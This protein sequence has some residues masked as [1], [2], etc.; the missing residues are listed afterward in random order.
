MSAFFSSYGGG[1]HHSAY[2]G[3]CPESRDWRPGDPMYAPEIDPTA[4]V[5]AF[6]TIDAGLRGPTRIG[7]RSWIMRHTH[8]GHDVQIGA[9]CELAPHC[10]VGGHVTLG[11]GVRV[12]QGAVFKPFVKVGDGARIGC[13]AVVVK[14]VPAGETWAGNPAHR[15]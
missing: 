15:L 2:I 5:E 6:T 1:I 12:G 7:A 10:S 8:C 13:G 9:D 11:T 3:G 4:R 14:D